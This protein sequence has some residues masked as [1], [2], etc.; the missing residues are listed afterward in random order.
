ML[1]LVLDAS[2]VLLE[3]VV[4]PDD[5]L[6]A[7]VEVEVEDVGEFDVDVDV[8]VALSFSLGPQWVLPMASEMITARERPDVRMRRG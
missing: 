1:P 4:A 8:S 2:D 6:D 3:P 7:E 5:S